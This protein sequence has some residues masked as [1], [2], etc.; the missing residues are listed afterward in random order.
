MNIYTGRHA[1]LVHNFAIEKVDKDKTTLVFPEIAY[2]TGTDWSPLDVPRHSRDIVNYLQSYLY[3][4]GA[5]IT[6][7]PVVIRFFCQK[8]RKGEM[9]ASDL[10]IFYI[11]RNEYIDGDETTVI[12]QD[13]VEIVV[14][15][16]G[17]FCTLCPDDMFDVEYELLFH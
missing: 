9:K 11:D 16:K 3:N 10:R 5:V 13:V 7:N 1:Q 6:L 8:V 14:D 2:N 4:L 17:N 12:G 15:D